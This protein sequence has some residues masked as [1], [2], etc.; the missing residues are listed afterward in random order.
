[1]LATL[2]IKLPYKMKSE[3][4]QIAKKT[5]LR[6]SDIVRDAVGSEYCPSSVSE[7]KRTTHPGS[8]EQRHIHRRR[9]F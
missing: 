1:M 8:A 5:H 6:K 2:T 4:N 9:H 3:L 7:H